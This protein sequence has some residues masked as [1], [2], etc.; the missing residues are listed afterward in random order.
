MHNAVIP[1]E[2][3][4]HLFVTK[5]QRERMVELLANATARPPQSSSHI[6]E[7]GSSG[8]RS[9]VLQMSCDGSASL[10]YSSH[11]R[12]VIC[13]SVDDLRKRLMMSGAGPEGSMEVLE[14]RRRSARTK[15]EALIASVQE[16]DKELCAVGSKYPA[17]VHDI[18]V[19]GICVRVEQRPPG[20]HVKIV[21]ALP[22]G[23]ILD[24]VAKVIHYSSATRRLGCEFVREHPPAVI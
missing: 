20:S 21:A 16:L 8:G 17:I 10:S 23:E 14:E 18:S 19:S 3:Q 22:S 4:A 13:D 2:G 12:L 9:V 24:T 11:E 6:I 1:S 7:S 5:H 15:P